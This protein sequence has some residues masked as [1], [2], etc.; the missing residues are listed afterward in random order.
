MRFFLSNIALMIVIRQTD[1]APIWVLPAS[2][3]FTI[4]R[5]AIK[6][7]ALEESKMAKRMSNIVCS[8]APCSAMTGLFGVFWPC[9][10]EKEWSCVALELSSAVLRHPRVEVSSWI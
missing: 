6:P 8:S 4:E 2:A 7:E 9:G 3:I 1:F 5:F 10:S